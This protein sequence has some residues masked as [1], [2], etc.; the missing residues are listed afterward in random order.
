MGAWGMRNPPIKLNDVIIICWHDS[1]RPRSQSPARDGVSTAGNRD[2]GRFYQLGHQRIKEKPGELGKPSG[3]GFPDLTVWE[4]LTGSGGLPG[5][6]ETPIVILPTSVPTLQSAVW[7]YGEAFSCYSLFLEAD[8]HATRSISQRFF[9][10]LG[11]CPDRVPGP[12]RRL[13][14]MARPPVRRRRRTRHC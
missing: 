7:Q 1:R 10:A 5:H 8:F 14:A 4:G 11:V 9:L 3:G 2:R 12:R 13:A 6:P